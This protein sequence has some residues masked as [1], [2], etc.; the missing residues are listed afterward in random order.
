MFF[1]L[2][3]DD[4]KMQEQPKQQDSVPSQEGIT[5]SIS[6]ESSPSG[7]TLS[8]IFPNLKVTVVKDAT[9]IFENRAD[10]GNF[11]IYNYTTFRRYIDSLQKI[12]EKAT[13]VLRDGSLEI[14][15]VEVILSNVDCQLERFVKI[16]VESDETW[17]EY[18]TKTQ[19]PAYAKIQ[20]H[21][22]GDQICHLILR[23]IGDD[24][25]GWFDEKALLIIACASDCD[26]TADYV[27]RIK[28]WLGEGS[29]FRFIK[30]EEEHSADELEEAI[31]KKILS[32]NFKFKEKRFIVKKGTRPK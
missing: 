1:S 26:Y 14:S 6:G 17:K 4:S 10:P 31:R 23:K 24:I 19:G 7:F 11:K 5:G 20:I 8:V 13:V 29:K 27:E 32:L 2:K 30:S 25:T 18:L 15:K 3:R 16:V 28:A 21:K 9:F 22:I 12:V